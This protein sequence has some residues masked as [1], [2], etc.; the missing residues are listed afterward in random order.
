MQTQKTAEIKVREDVLR[1]TLSA[2][3]NGVISFSS[4]SKEEV[5]C[6]IESV[7]KDTQKAFPETFGGNNF[8]KAYK[9]G[10]VPCLTLIASKV[11]ISCSREKKMLENYGV[12]R[13]ASSAE[14]AYE[15]LQQ[16]ISPEAQSLR[17][18][19]HSGRFGGHLHSTALSGLLEDKNPGKMGHSE[20]YNSWFSDST[21]LLAHLSVVLSTNPGWKENPESRLL[22]P[23]LRS[24]IHAM[25]ELE[26]HRDRVLHKGNRCSV[27][28]S[29][30]ED[31]VMGVPAVSITVANIAADGK[32]EEQTNVIRAARDGVLT[33]YTYESA[34]KEP[35]P[36][37]KTREVFKGTL[38][39]DGFISI[40]NTLPSNLFSQITNVE[41]SHETTMNNKTGANEPWVEEGGI[42]YDGM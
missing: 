24:A 23:A 6:C 14:E 34:G 10:K 17:C 18:R 8:L 5:Q 32:G 27:I 2:A 21:K 40:E 11:N 42:V 9:E 35:L 37:S 29:C 13:G 12:E 1:K 3:L 25:R 4:V 26:T 20:Y 38:S 31:G 15:T 30:S 36:M 22:L 33:V 19:I 16:D 7:R 41:K 39:P 28:L